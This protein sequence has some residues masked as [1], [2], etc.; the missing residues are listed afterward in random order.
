MKLSVKNINKCHQSET[1]KTCLENKNKNKA[2]ILF[3]VCILPFKISFRG[4][5]IKKTLPPLLSLRKIPSHNSKSRFPKL[6][7]NLILML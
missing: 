5:F 7:Y 2:R 1:R 4:F 6:K 3:P